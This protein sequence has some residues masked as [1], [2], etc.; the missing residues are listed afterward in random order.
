MLECWNKQFIGWGSYQ[1]RRQLAEDCLLHLKEKYSYTFEQLPDLLATT[2][3]VDG[4]D[5]RVIF[6]PE[7]YSMKSDKKTNAMGWYSY[8]TMGAGSHSWS[9]F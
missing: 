8:K 6:H 4:K 7:E 9:C 2:L 3:I 5:L 1:I